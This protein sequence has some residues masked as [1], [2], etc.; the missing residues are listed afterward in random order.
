MNVE[1]LI[2][3][4]VTLGRH[5]IMV[6]K[7]C[8]IRTLFFR[9]CLVCVLVSSGCARTP[10]HVP[11]F[12]GTGVF[13]GIL[14]PDHVLVEGA[15]WSRFIGDRLVD[16]SKNPDLLYGARL[17]QKVARSSGILHPVPCT[18]VHCALDRARLLGARF[19]IT[20]SIRRVVSGHDRLTMNLWSVQPSATLLQTM[21]RG[22]TPDW[23]NPHS[24]A[25][26]LKKIA[27][28]FLQPGVIMNGA[29]GLGPEKDPGRSLERYLDKGQVDQALRLGQQLASSSVLGGKS[30]FF[31]LEY[32]RTLRA[33]GRISLAKELVAVVMDHGS[34]NGDFVLEAANMEKLEGHPKKVRDLYYQGLLRLPDDGHLWSE[35][36]EDRL[37]KGHPRQA[38]FLVRRYRRKHPGKLGDRMAGVIYAAYVMSGQSEKADR[39]WQNE[40]VSIHRRRTLLVRHA[41]LYRAAE[42][43]RLRIVRKK[44]QS[45]IS[46]GFASE[47]IYHDLMVA[48]GGMG[49]PIEEIEV[50]RKAIQ[51]GYASSW[52]REQVKALESKGY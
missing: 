17:E 6:L 22:V 14:D 37:W 13:D 39:W 40:F 16:A 35:V 26:F 51:D 28:D 23:R 10:V 4:V 38:L 31:N 29:H 36:M 21:S 42:Q 20:A 48:L 8:D 52:I 45:W 24:F 46:Q 47:P 30:A 27:S 41:W 32:L 49:E 9:I 25:S 12:S 33:A 44:A 1:L 3:R 19:L 15:V 34:V 50:G 5:C 18:D 43:G 2:C 7:G 11:R